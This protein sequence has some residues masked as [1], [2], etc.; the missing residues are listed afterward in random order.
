MPVR[1]KD[2][3]IIDLAKEVFQ[4][5][6]R[7]KIDPDRLLLK[8]SRLALL[9]SNEDI[10]YWLSCERNGY[11][12]N[13]ERDNSIMRNMFRFDCTG[14]R[15]IWEPLPQLW[16]MLNTSKTSFKQLSSPGAPVMSQL[17]AQT[18][19]Q[20]AATYSRVI[21]TVLASIHSYAS[22]TYYEKLFS[23]LSET[24]FE[25]YKTKIDSLLASR[26]GDTLQKISA[27]SERL[28]SGDSEG[29]SQGM[30][31]CRRLID[32]FADSLSLPE[33][34]QIMIGEEE[35]DVS[36]GRTKNR[37]RAYVHRKT[38]SDGQKAKLRQNFNNLYERVCK[39]IHG[40]ISSNE[41]RALLLNT[42]LLLG[43]II[44]L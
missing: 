31:T 17:N 9:Q 33:Q 8:A 16:H 43:E 29:I 25:R 12:P 38:D 1:S 10:S 23:N 4:D 18:E 42:Y 11:N 37:I 7:N 14:N 6:E 24:I 32:N 26:A 40:E 36:K 13:L 15:H 5:V 30:S 21:D 20:N 35:L 44:E 39:G 41:A 3:E 2:K 28:S 22:Q 19:R 27:V 34:A